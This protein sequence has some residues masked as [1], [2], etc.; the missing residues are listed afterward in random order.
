[1]QKEKKS[2]K[3]FLLKKLPL[4]VLLV[5]AG[6][7]AALIMAF[8]NEKKEINIQAARPVSIP[9]TSQSFRQI[10]DRNFKLIQPLLITETVDESEKLNSMK[11]E[12]TRFITKQKEEG[13]ITS[14][15][16]YVSRLKDGSWM[17]INKNETFSPGSLMKIP[18]L[19]TVLKDAERKPG[20][21]EE[22][23]YFRKH[24]SGIPEATIT[25]EPLV[26]NRFYKVSDL[27]YYMI[28]YSDND[29]TALLNNYL[30][31]E[32]MK[33]LFADLQLP[34]PNYRQPDYKIDVA[35]CAKFL[36]ILFNATYLNKEMS[37]YAME[38]LSKSA[39]KE[40]IIK[41]LDPSIVVA[42]KFGERNVDGEQQLHEFGIVYYDDDPY[43]LGVMTK[44]GNHL[45]LPQVLSGV[46]D[47]IYQSMKQ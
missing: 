31:F 16:V 36:K 21:L 1:M 29:A 47:L 41:D 30:N 8:Y 32:T 9:S 39:Y 24:F 15:S 7:V 17:A 3:L 5:L 46:S 33:K 22:K 14:A 28:V 45:I 20:I 13:V 37:Q 12:V 40:G 43:L 2:W 10:R 11:E 26:E 34:V 27:L 4:Y 38:L 18:T 19:I 6:F 25:G 42:H 44:G 35:D 23:I